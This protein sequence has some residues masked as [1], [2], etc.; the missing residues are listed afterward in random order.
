VKRFRAPEEA[1]A[2]AR[3]WQVVRAAFEKRERVNWPRHHARSLAAAAVLAAAVA[4]LLSPP[5]RSVIH[6]LRKAVGIEHAKRELFSLPARGRLLVQAR[7]GVWVVHADGS[8]RKLAGYRAASW[9]PHGLYLVATRPNE[10]AT[11]EDNGSVHW[12]LAR[13]RVRFPRWAGT[14]TDTRI[15]YADRERVPAIRVVGG[16]GKGDHWLAKDFVPIAPAWRPGPKHVL[17]VAHTDGRV[18]LW[19]ADT[20]ELVATSPKLPRAIELAWSTDGSRLFALAPHR[21]SILD[22]RARVVSVQRFPAGTIAAA[23]GVPPRGTRVALLLRRGGRSEV[24]VLGRA[25]RRAFSGT[26]QFTG[27]AWSPDGRWLLVTWKEANQWIFIRSARV[28]TIRAV[29]GISSQF[30]SGTFPTLAGWCCARSG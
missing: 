5:G 28:K 27:L 16:D 17:A 1:E 29:S 7:S 6:S 26:G 18:R 23:M 19:E 24:G 8:K 4:A 20:R 11:L 21:L 3:A 2:A 22:A 25:Y 14:R 10:L 13:P 9:S 30:G 12:T 15:A